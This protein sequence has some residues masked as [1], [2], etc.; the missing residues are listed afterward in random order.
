M[1]QAM[2]IVGVIGMMM[3]LFAGSAW[4]QGTLTPPG[5][6]GPTMK[7]L[8]QIEPR[9]PI[10]SLPYTISQPG[11]YCL[12]ASLAVTSDAAVT[13]A[14]DDV[15]LDLNG[16][17]ISNSG[18]A[19]GDYCLSIRNASRVRVSNGILVGGHSSAYVDNSQ[20]AILSGLLIS[21]PASNGV[22]I[23][24]DCTNAVVRNCVISNPDPSFAFPR[25]GIRVDDRNPGTCIERNI[26]GGGTRG[27]YIH[28]G[29]T[30]IRVVGNSV[31]GFI[32][33]GIYTFSA[34]TVEVKENL[35]RG[36]AA[37]YAIAIAGNCDGSV[38]KNN[39]LSG[40]GVGLLVYAS[41]Y[42][43]IDNNTIYAPTTLGIEFTFGA[44]NSVYRSNVIR[45][46]GASA[47]GGDWMGSNVD[48][49]GNIL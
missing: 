13:I 7:T 45:N 35:V 17:R 16:F 34:A 1:R 18:N 12:A 41:D 24:D 43:L 19:V 37:N 14:S 46:S 39:Y 11:S 22:F 38:V 10:S 30:G 27:I 33:Q 3:V 15:S 29:G 26:I 44:K 48:G 5:A 4:A 2:R 32:N 9:T 21:D 8:D 36:N 6:P 31:T 23:D 40:S 42:L 20:Q 47:V 28:G 49:G 25:T